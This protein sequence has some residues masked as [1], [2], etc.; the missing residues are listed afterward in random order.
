MLVTIATLCA[1]GF[2]YPNDLSQEAALVRAMSFA[3]TVEK[4][5]RDFEDVV[6][7]GLDLTEVNRGPN[8]FLFEFKSCR[9]AVD[10]RSG[11]VVG[12]RDERG[13]D[14]RAFDLLQPMSPLAI[15]RLGK[16]Y[17]GM[18]GLPQPAAT[19]HM[20]FWPMP[21]EPGNYIVDYL[22]TYRGIPRDI[23][24]GCFQV[25][26][27]DRTG[28]LIGFTEYEEVPFS[29]PSDLTP[30]FD[31]AIA[32]GRLI[33]E[34]FGRDPYVE[35]LIDNVRVQLALWIP[36]RTFG[37]RT[38]TGISAAEVEYGQQGKAMLVYTAV[39][40]DGSTEFEAGRFYI[41]KIGAHDGRLLSYDAYGHPA[42][43]K[44]A[45]FAWDIG[46]V[47]A[48]VF[49]GGEL[50]RV[51]GAQVS[52]IRAG[53]FEQEL[54]DVQLTIGHL[55]IRADYDTSQGILRHD[56]EKGFRY[57]R[58]NAALRHVLDD[59]KRYRFNAKSA[60][61]RMLMPGPSTVASKRSAP[62]LSK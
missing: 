53:R 30:A 40:A 38:V 13:F 54:Q 17:L 11:R 19:H 5:P 48:Q 46:P 16:D 31:T 49:Y 61:G 55:T 35:V 57:G 37:A 18:S 41:V 21:K 8:S 50:R 10:F 44:K 24:N 42:L 4:G 20:F 2:S 15:E 58:P 27:N 33:E 59:V 7:H 36:R 51:S 43:Q 25:S 9:V 6:P 45:P 62:P 47:D 23:Q 26:M 56:S 22:P 34:V 3:R 60:R 39:L 12:Y 29:P 14:Y 1:V 28:R 52:L 32:R